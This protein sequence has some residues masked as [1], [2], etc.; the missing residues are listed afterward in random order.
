MDYQK[1]IGGEFQHAKVTLGDHTVRIYKSDGAHNWYLFLDVY[2]KDDEK[3]FVHVPILM[4]GLISSQDYAIL[5][6][7]YYEAQYDEIK[8]QTRHGMLHEAVELD[9]PP[10]VKG[11]FN[12]RYFGEGSMTTDLPINSRANVDFHLES[13]AEIAYRRFEATKGYGDIHPWTDI[14]DSIQHGWREVVKAL[15]YPTM[16]MKTPSVKSP[17]EVIKALFP[18]G[19]VED[20]PILEDRI[21]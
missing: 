13:L 15:F 1:S 3:P 4:P 10:Q 8:Y 14:P 11:D 2:F 17:D 12:W 7:A 18:Q 9:P 16:E 6:A 19:G 21:G 5:V 20:K